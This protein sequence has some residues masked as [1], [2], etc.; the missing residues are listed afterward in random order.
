MQIAFNQARA[1][2]ALIPPIEIDMKELRVRKGINASDI[3]FVGKEA[4]K[5]PS[6]AR[7]TSQERLIFIV[8][9]TLAA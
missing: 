1:A 4:P 6:P 8:S 3:V 7:E 5:T 2:I 9:R